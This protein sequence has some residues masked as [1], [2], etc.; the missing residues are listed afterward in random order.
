MIK[1]NQG[2]HP[3]AAKARQRVMPELLGPAPGAMKWHSAV[4]EEC[5]QGQ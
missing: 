5:T 2:I 4:A 1:P 3:T